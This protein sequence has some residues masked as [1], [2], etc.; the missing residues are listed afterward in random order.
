[1]QIVA[2]WNKQASVLKNTGIIITNC[3]LIKQKK[4]KITCLCDFCFLL[5]FCLQLGAD[6]EAISK[7]RASCFTGVSKHSKTIK[8][9]GLTASGFHQ[10]S[11]V[12]KPRY[13]T[14][15]RFWNITY[16]LP[17]EMNGLMSSTQLQLGGTFRHFSYQDSGVSQIFIRIISK[18]EK[19]LSN[20]NVVVWR[21]IKRENS[22]LPVAV[23]FS[24]TRV[25]KLP[26]NCGG[27]LVIKPFISRGKLYCYFS[28]RRSVFKYPGVP[29]L[30]IPAFWHSII[31]AF[32]V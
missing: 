2:T 20:V 26:P 5:F 15:T 12:W 32:R 31:P 21:Q 17:R 6:W 24:K 14:R 29:C 19:I 27:V 28:F 7:T 13:N 4:A 22:S 23:R 1:M 9:L 10:F 25:L 16:S 18:G 3:A 11:H 30:S 8:A